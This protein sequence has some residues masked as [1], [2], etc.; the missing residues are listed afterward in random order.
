MS[1]VYLITGSS[2]GFG[3]A[4]AQTLLNSGDIVIATARDPADLSFDGTTA[5]NYL[6]LKLDVTSRSDIDAA[7]ASAVEKFGRV[8]AVINNAAFSLVGPLETLSEA[9]IRHQ[10]DVNFFAVATITQKA[11]QTMRTQTP[12]GGIII[13]VSSMMGAFGVPMLSALSASKFAVE[14]FT[15]AVRQEMK[16]EWGIKLVSVKPGHLATDATS[17]SMVYGE[18]PVPE[19]DHMDGKL[20][21]KSLDTVKT[22]DPKTIARLIYTLS[23]MDNPPPRA[24]LSHEILELVK[25]SLEEERKM[26]FNHDLVQLLQDLEE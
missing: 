17:K 10:F 15:E 12:S 9:Q 19:Y 7:F 3:H 20:W 13:Q 14:G 26:L 16:P 6:P 22:A 2:R 1:R 4:I 21:V 18:I 24:I 25:A 8:D 11:I 23:K 5:N